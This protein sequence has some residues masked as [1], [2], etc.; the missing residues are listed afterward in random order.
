M[1]ELSDAF[2]RALTGRSPGGERRSIR[3]QL[4][5]IERRA[6]SVK[7]AA[8]ETG[9]S[10]S[11]WRRWKSGKSKPRPQNADKVRRARRRIYSAD[12]RQAAAGSVGGSGGLTITGDVTISRDTRPRSL[13][14]GPYL[15]QARIQAVLNAFAEGDMAE[16]EAQLQAAIIEYGISEPTSIENPVITF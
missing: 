3:Q 9:V 14:M 16:L 11:T 15:S 10:E 4:G 13:V 1:G 5:D 8:R 12:Q 2:Y 7:A 6:G